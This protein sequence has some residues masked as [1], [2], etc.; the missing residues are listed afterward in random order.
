HARGLAEPWLACEKT[1]TRSRANESSDNRDGAESV[2]HDTSRWY[3]SFYWRI[4]LGFVIFVITVIV[5]QSV[6]FGYLMSRSNLTQ[7]MPSPNNVAIMVE[8][9]LRSALARD[10]ALDLRGYLARE[11][12]RSP[13]QVCVVMKDGRVAC[14]GS[15]PL[16]DTARRTAAAALAGVDFTLTGGN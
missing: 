4:G 11:Y 8:G 12:G 5:A 1:L 16:S 6:M 9:D 13:F 7:Q 3:R 2:Q 15:K 10:P 14:N